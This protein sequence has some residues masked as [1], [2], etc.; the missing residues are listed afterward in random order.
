MTDLSNR[1]QLEHTIVNVIN[2][3]RSIGGRRVSC[4]NLPLAFTR[5]YNAIEALDTQYTTHQTTTAHKND[6]QP[7]C[8]GH[9]CNCNRYNYSHFHENDCTCWDDYALT[10]A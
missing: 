4:D 7:P 10:P 2:A 6:I 5:L 8:G 9:I 3:Y 1:T